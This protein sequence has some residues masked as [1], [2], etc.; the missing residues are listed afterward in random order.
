MGNNTE[1][2]NSQI[3]TQSQS[4]LEAFKD[5]VELSVN[6]KRI[7]YIAKVLKA[8]AMELKHAK[9]AT[10]IS[11]LNE[12]E[13][14]DRINNINQVLQKLT[15][16]D[17]FY[18]ANKFLADSNLAKEEKELL[19]E[20]LKDS[21]SI[22]SM[23]K[24]AIR[25]IREDMWTE[26]LQE[27]FES[28]FAEEIQIHTNNLTEDEKT[29]IRAEAIKHTKKSSV[30]TQLTKQA[31]KEFY[32][33]KEYYI[34]N[35]IESAEKLRE[36]LEDIYKANLE[37]KLRIRYIAKTYIDEKWNSVDLS[38]QEIW[39]N[40]KDATDIK[41]E[42]FN[43]SDET[44]NF[45]VELAI[46]DLPT[47]LVSGWIAWIAW[48][49]VSKWLKAWMKIDDVSKASFGARS[50]IFLT[51]ATTEWATFT[52]SYDA[53]R[54]RELFLNNP[55][56][57]KHVWLNTFFFGAAR[58]LWMNRFTSINPHLEG[59]IKTWLVLPAAV[60]TLDLALSYERLLKQDPDL[61]DELLKEFL[62]LSILGWFMH[63]APTAISWIR[64]AEANVS[65]K[66]VEIEVN[67]NTWQTT[68]KSNGKEA[69]IQT[70]RE[71]KTDTKV[72]EELISKEKAA[73][74][75]KKLE[76]QVK[77]LG[78]KIETV[79]I[80]S[81]QAYEVT[82]KLI[83]K[84]RELKQKIAKLKLEDNV[85]QKDLEVLQSEIRLRDQETT[86]LKEQNTEMDFDLSMSKA[87]EE[88]AMTNLRISRQEVKRLTKELNQN[89]ATLK[90]T[91][92]KISDLEASLK[93]S[94][95]ELQ[96]TKKQ[97][98]Q[99][100]K[101]QETNTALL[102]KHISELNV[103]LKDAKDL[104]ARLENLEVSLKEKIDINKK[105]E[106]EL[107]STRKQNLEIKDSLEKTNKEIKTRNE[108]I[109]ELK[110]DLENSKQA[111]ELSSKQIK[112]KQE[113]INKLEAE[114]QWFEKLKSD[115]K[116]L[117]EELML[118]EMEI[119]ENLAKMQKMDSRITELE[120][121]NNKISETNSKLHLR[122][123]EL[124]TRLKEKWLKADKSSEILKQEII[125][126]NEIIRKNEQIQKEN[127]KKL[128]QLKQKEAEINRLT[129]ENLTKSKELLKK[130]EEIKILSEKYLKLSKEHETAKKK[131]SEAEKY[132]VRTKQEVDEAKQIIKKQE[133]QINKLRTKIWVPNLDFSEHKKGLEE[134]ISDL[135]KL[136]LEA[137]EVL[138]D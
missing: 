39:E 49:T 60:V 81:T 71:L 45:M 26:Q 15:Q 133:E 51:R 88:I 117:S 109:I 104:K 89:W 113:K 138:K 72:K 32:K 103:R 69:K 91:R 10:S 18:E 107:Q 57:K 97:K 1:K 52:A 125:A 66:K 77:D 24:N 67:D 2:L 38:K 95:Q 134:I 108:E 74:K 83:G 105:L 11:F 80:K 82:K 31:I 137:E 101:L 118:R 90:V 86:R 13:K 28:R 128:D 40:Y 96:Q 98:S 126:K 7:D 130:Q 94:K 37:N 62:I 85:K 68:I 14:E 124:Q 30:E 87:S 116:K 48:K 135:D 9:N 63:L 122:I 73:E 34:Q 27:I 75:I 36:K 56:W 50:A 136:I 70:P 92:T 41:D 93:K 29:M 129:K 120:A 25:L 112:I 121:S 6:E 53:L 106:T 114:L 59:L 47:I 76:Q 79:K 110:R 54:Y 64:K 12:E 35:W 115:Y 8:R 65:W 100:K 99:Q 61:K 17:N 22:P 127:K 21:T 123:I 111:W 102:E 84:V 23:E 58:V 55:E 119:W 131:L 20:L 33:N 19:N 16:F 42:W 46:Y 78:L 44:F 4:A 5:E 3:E 43:I 132:W